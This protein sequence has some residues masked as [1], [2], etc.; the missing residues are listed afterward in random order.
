MYHH[1]NLNNNRKNRN[2]KNNTKSTGDEAPEVASRGAAE[3][4]A[5]TPSRSTE[6]RVGAREGLM[7]AAQELGRTVAV[8]PES[9]AVLGLAGQRGVRYHKRVR[10]RVF[11]DGAAVDAIQGIFK[12]VLAVILA[13][14]VRHTYL[15]QKH[16]DFQDSWF[17]T[18]RS[19]F[20]AM[21]LG[22]DK[23]AVTR[24]AGGGRSV[25]L[26]RR[27]SI[28]ADMEH[29]L[30]KFKAWLNLTEKEERVMRAKFTGAVVSECFRLE[31]FDIIMAR[32][33]RKASYSEGG[34][35]GSSLGGAIASSSGAP[36]AQAEC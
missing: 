29:V 2:D 13:L 33:A 21:G 26:L 19:T 28:E 7:S 23:A 17:E 8:N 9:E 18:L 35:G 16:T 30:A 36:A 27:P 1:D 6:T 22:I 20:E 4:I 10:E 5:V 11:V 15:I 3:D 32:V 31:T 12:W 24:G 25:I 34:S 14:E